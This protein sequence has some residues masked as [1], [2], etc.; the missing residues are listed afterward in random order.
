LD[1][2]HFEKKLLAIYSSRVQVTML[3]FHKG[4]VGGLEELMCIN[5]PL[6]LSSL[7]SKFESAHTPSIILQYNFFQ[8]HPSLERPK[9]NKNCSTFKYSEDKNIFSYL[10]HST[11]VLKMAVFKL[12]KPKFTALPVLVPVVRSDFSSVYCCHISVLWLT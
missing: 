7:F 12:F 8:I 10:C 5:I 1:K 6:T 11:C 2:P 4:D 3:H 9:K